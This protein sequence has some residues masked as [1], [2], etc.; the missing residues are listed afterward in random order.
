M[1]PHTVTRGAARYAATDGFDSAWVDA[2]CHAVLSNCHPKQRAFVEDPHRRVSAMV[3][4]RG[5][6]TTGQRARFLLKMLRIP[7]AKCIYIALTRQSAEELMWN[8]ILDL[9]ARL[10]IDCTPNITKLKVTLNRNGSTLML[11]GADDKKQVEKL[12]GQKYHEVAIDEA[13]SF[14]G[15]LLDNLISRII[16]PALGDYRGV[17]TMFGTP[18][19]QLLGPFYEATRDGSARHRRYGDR[20]LPEYADWTAWSSHRW[21]LLDG[22]ATVP[23]MANA[24]DEALQ[25]KKDQGWSDDHPIWSREWLG[26]WSADDTENVYKYRPHREDGTPWM[27]W[28]P[29]RVGPLQFAELPKTFMDWEYGYG[30]DFGYSDAFALTVFAFSPSDPS[31]TLWQVYEFNRPK[32]Y[33]RLIA[34]LLLGPELD[35]NKPGGVIGR[36]GWPAAMVADKAGYG[37]AQISELRE[38]YGIAMIGAEKGHNYKLPAI[39][40]FNGDLLDGRIRVLKGSVLETQ[41]MTLQWIKDQFDVVTENKGQTNDQADSALYCRI[42]IA[43]MFSAAGAHEAPRAEAPKTARDE[44]DEPEDREQ[45]YDNLLGGD[46]DSALGY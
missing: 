38:V 15:S 36:T 40:L 31:R 25:E 19:H 16:G 37:D 45:N 46:Y 5:G 10:G 2:K 20:D 44:P 7:N 22:A 21:T 13:A 23:A 42:A 39:E 26:R 17:L 27:Q 28:D 3:G 35:H 12:R 24:W 30:M 6:K 18:G 41:L 43:S 1:L 9:L 11:V 4:R 8:P 34:E 29:P 32:M 33:S 14:A